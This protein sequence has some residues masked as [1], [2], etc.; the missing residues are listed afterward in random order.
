MKNHQATAVVCNSH[1]QAQEAVD[2]WQKEGHSLNGLS[3]VGKDYPRNETAV[4]YPD[5]GDQLKGRD[6]LGAF[7]GNLWNLLPGAALLI[8]PGIGPLLIAGLLVR[9]MEN[10]LAGAV[11]TESR[12]ALERAFSDLGIP[13]N[14]APGYETEI[15]AGN[16]IVIAHGP[17]REVD[18]AN[19]TLRSRR[20]QPSPGYQM[21]SWIY[22]VA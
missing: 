22:P 21:N 2:T 13:K 8:I 12:N 16:F 9:S 17:A 14:L 6:A 4:G 20:R 5:E 1:E 7:W 19:V 15:N 11:T 3:V 10:A 18:E